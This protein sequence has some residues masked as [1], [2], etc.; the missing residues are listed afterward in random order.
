M[1]LLAL[2]SDPKIVLGLVTAASVFGIL[3]GSIIKP[4][5]QLFLSIVLCD[6]QWLMFC[7]RLK[8]EWLL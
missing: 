2:V 1:I 3:G 8:Y 5:I 6:F 4:G 7:R